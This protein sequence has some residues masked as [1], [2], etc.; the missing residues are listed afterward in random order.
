MKRAASSAR[1]DQDRQQRQGTQ[2]LQQLAAQPL[3]NGAK[4]SKALGNALPSMGSPAQGAVEQAPQP[5]RRRPKKIS[6]NL[7]PWIKRPRE[8]HAQSTQGQSLAVEEPPVQQ[9]Q[10]K[11]PLGGLF[12]GLRPL[13]SKQ[14][15][16]QQ[17]QQ[18]QEQ[19]EEGQAEVFEEEEEAPVQQVQPKQPLGGLFAGLR[20]L[21]SKQQRQQPQEDV[22]AEVYEEE[23]PEP[24]GRRGN[25]RSSFP[26]KLLPWLRTT[27]A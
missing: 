6:P 20:P 25:G 18:E 7:M 11:Q 21:M 17:Q 26:K 15:Q 9:E 27:S 10:P 5:V 4:A 16:Q 23:E 14:Q 13:M 19:E 2:P 8:E 1:R 3:S 12:A 22:Q 24:V